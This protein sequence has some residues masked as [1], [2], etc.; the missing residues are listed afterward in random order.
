MDAHGLGA[1]ED[2]LAERAG[3][4]VADEQHRGIGARQIVAQ[5]MLDA[6]GIGHAGGGHDDGAALD[7]C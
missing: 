5:V 7:L 2:D 6:A 1:G 4:L 3:R